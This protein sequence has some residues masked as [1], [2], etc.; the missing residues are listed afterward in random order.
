MLTTLPA[1]FSVATALAKDTRIEVTNLP[2]SGRP[3]AALGR[4]FE[5]PDADTLALLKNADAVVTIGKL[6]KEDPLY[7]AARAQNLRVV[8]ID[9]TEPF[10]ATLPGISLAREP[11]ADAPWAPRRSGDAGAPQPGRNFWLSPSN[12]AR[13]ADIIAQ[14]F[15]RLAPADAAVIARNAQVLR[16]AL[17]DLKNTYDAKF[18]EASDA[19]LFGLAA[20][21]VY[22]AV[23]TGLFV[24]GYFVRQDVDW[25]PADLAALTRYLKSHAIKVVVHKWEPAQPI[26]D[27]IRAGGARLVVIRT[28]DE[29][30]KRDGLLSADSYLEDLRF[31]LDALYGAMKN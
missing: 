4:F 31:D 5:R 3:P 30:V 8:N 13:M 17:L 19:S 18:T 27:A 24:D 11:G 15:M 2:P 23:D 28:G 29:G 25:T 26:Q 6:W 7:A 16:R 20:E 21:L 1:T 12:G 9:A 14:D 10:S 22:L